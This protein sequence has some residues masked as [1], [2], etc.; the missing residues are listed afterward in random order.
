M[1]NQKNSFEYVLIMGLLPLLAGT[2]NILTAAVVSISAVVITILL[3]I[4]SQFVLNR[5]DNNDSKWLIL[6]ALGLS[7]A[8]LSHYL[9][10]LRFPLIIDSLGLYI[11]LLG[12]TPLVYIGASEK[13]E[14][15]AVFKK[16]GIFFFLM[17]SIGTVREILGQ[18]AFFGINFMEAGYAPMSILENAAGAFIT[19]A[20][21]FFLVKVISLKISVGADTTQI[22]R[23]HSID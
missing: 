5:I 2:V 17:L 19:V 22:R 15:G 23:G 21:V 16:I 8:Y 7:L 20:A 6:F 14:W 3:S 18:G 4:F 12:V 1:T 13:V 10:M 9:I 11:I